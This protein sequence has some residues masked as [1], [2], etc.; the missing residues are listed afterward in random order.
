MNEGG[1]M[2]SSGQAAESCGKDAAPPIDHAHFERQT[3]G[4]AALQAEVLGLLAEQMKSAR[5][6]MSDASPAE[7]AALAHGLK[8]AA[9]G[10]GAFSLADCCDAIEKAPDLDG[11][12]HRLNQQIDVVL[13]FVARKRI[14]PYCG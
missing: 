14:P 1:H 11:P 9:R 6:A 12:M 3:M 10:V 13:E 7:R 5:A 8:G 2:A 4:D